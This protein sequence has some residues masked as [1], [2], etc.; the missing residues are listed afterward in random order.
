MAQ[1]PAFR[2][3]EAA[4]LFKYGGCFPGEQAAVGQLF[5]GFAACPV[6]FQVLG[7]YVT[8]YQFRNTSADAEILANIP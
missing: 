2:D 1:P 8:A 5:H 7:V 3:D 4:D 6:N